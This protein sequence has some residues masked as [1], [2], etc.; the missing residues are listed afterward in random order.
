MRNYR[1]LSLGRWNEHGP[2]P[3]ED[4]YSFHGRSVHVRP[5]GDVCRFG[6]NVSHYTL[7]TRSHDYKPVSFSHAHTHWDVHSSAGLSAH[8]ERNRVHHGRGAR[9]R[10]AIR[11]TSGLP[12]F[13]VCTGE[14]NNHHNNSSNVLDR[15]TCGQIV[16]QCMPMHYRLRRT[17]NSQPVGG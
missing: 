2:S 1:Y 9:T 10:S 11:S 12:E 7:T 5:A 8:R 14:R 13:Y 4:F 17:S 3:I 6:I 15:D 16:R